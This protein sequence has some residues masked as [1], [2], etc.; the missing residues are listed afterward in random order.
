MAVDGVRRLI[1]ILLI[2]LVTLLWITINITEEFVS[3]TWYLIGGAIALS[4]L[5]GMKQIFKKVRVL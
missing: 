3:G 2:T 5:L 4:V 1:F